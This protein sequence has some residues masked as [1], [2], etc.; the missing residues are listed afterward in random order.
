M[1][2]FMPSAGR[3]HELEGYPVHSRS[4]AVLAIVTVC[5]KVWKYKKFPWIEMSLNGMQSE[6]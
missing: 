2:L 4:Y 3:W 5:Q 1:V 6:K